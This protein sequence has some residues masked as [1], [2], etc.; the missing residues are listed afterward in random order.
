MTP[1][2]SSTA[3]FPTTA[4][5]DSPSFESTSGHFP[6]PEPDWRSGPTDSGL[7]EPGSWRDASS[8]VSPAAPSAY[9]QS[10]YSAGYPGPDYSEPATPAAGYAE[11]GGRR[12][13]GYREDSGP[14]ATDEQR[15]RYWESPYPDP[16]T[17]DAGYQPA[18]PELSGYQRPDTMGDAPQEPPTAG[19]PYGRGAPEYPTGAR[20]RVGAE[21]DEGYPPQEYPTG[22]YPAAQSHPN[23]N[24]PDQDYPD[25]DYPDRAYA[26]RSRP[27][28][29]YQEE[30]SDSPY[31]TYQERDPRYDDEYAPGGRYSQ[32]DYQQGQ[33]PQDDYPQGQYPQDE[34]PEQAPS[35]QEPYAPQQEYVARR[36]APSEEEP[37]DAYPDGYQPDDAYP[38]QRYAGD[39][40]EYA[41]GPEPEAPPHRSEPSRAGA[42]SRAAAAALQPVPFSWWRSALAAFA[43]GLLTAGLL[44]GA[45]ID[46]PAYAAIC[47]GVQALFVAAW[48]L[49]MRPPGPRVVAGVGIAAAVGADIAAVYSSGASLA[50]L[51][52]VMAGGVIVGI[53]SQLL[54][55]EGRARVTE[56]VG[57]TLVVVIATVGM[58][59]PILL[60]RQP[61]GREALYVCLLAAGIGLVVARL[62]DLVLRAPRV[63]PTVPR[64]AIGIVLGAMAGTAAA[65]FAGSRLDTVITSLAAVGGLVVALSAVLADLGMV[66]AEI[67]SRLD[68]ED[69]R[70]RIPRTL[71]GPFV[72]FAVAAPAAYLLSVLVIVNV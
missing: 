19:E 68:D 20:P 71:L 7:D 22:E 69:E 12:G 45:A 5:S 56:S 47:L 40:E 16:A 64:G 67:G 70:R 38:Q 34:Y 31:P 4:P 59:T 44:I 10:G 32:D 62:L 27:E 21:Y 41:E 29:P 11:P 52:Y 35:E 24:Y 46:Q 6:P 43:S 17:P 72:A 18:A 30:Q 37:D 60:T 49:G 9:P 36:Y 65:T 28:V 50:P 54:R 8:P 1:T 13:A 15:T 48:T 42:G 3:A 25:Q 26:E 58:A 53:V 51:G 39:G 14:A 63:T 33:Y 61:G 66:F 55:G 23:Q 57:S 2:A